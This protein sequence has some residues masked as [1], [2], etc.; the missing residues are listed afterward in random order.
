M[1]DT[2]YIVLLVVI[3][4]LA[5]M[6]IPRIF[7][8][9]AI[10]SVIKILRENNAVGRKGAK[11]IEEL[12]LQPKS[13]LERL[14]RPRDYKPR[15]LQLLIGADIVETTEDGKIYLSEENLAATKWKN[16]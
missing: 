7:I 8:G 6:V 12:G 1:N 11:T 4:I 16:N 10:N 3:M 14:T 2:L 9:R 5:M 15:A 13:L